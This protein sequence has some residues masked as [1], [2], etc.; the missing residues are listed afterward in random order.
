[1]RL[2]AI[3]IG[4]NSVRCTVV[5]VP[6]GGPRVRLDD[7][8]AY[9]RL[10]RGT[11]V[12]GHLDQAAMDETV[13]A[14]GRMLQ[15]ARGR[16]V[17]HVRAVATA[18]VRNAANGPAFVARIRE[19]LGLDVEVISEEHEGRLA[20]LSAAEAVG[21][22]GRAAVVDIGGA[23]VE[24]VRS[25]GGDITSAVSLP[26]GAVVTTERF[27]SQNRLSG[28]AHKELTR[29]V[30]ALLAEALTDESAA[31]IVVGS[32]GTVVAIAAL[33]SA[34]GAAT[35]SGL[36]GLTVSADDVSR[37]RRM[38]VASSAA[39]RTAMKGMPASR[40]D[41][42]TAGAVVLDEAL[43]ALGAPALTVNARGMRE[44]IIIEA[45]QRERGVE[46]PLDRMGWIR[47]F[48]R[49]CRSDTLHAEQVRRLA[50]ELFDGLAGG[51]GLD[52]ASRPLLEAAALLH[53]VGYCVAYE[54]H[55]KHSHHLISHAELPGF[56]PEE[57]MLIAGIARYHRG[58]LPKMKHPEFGALDA[59]GRGTVERLA[60]LLRVAD[61]LDRS[62]AQRVGRLTVA[63]GPECAEVRITGVPPL[64][65][66]I[67]GAE[68]KADLFE[69]VFDRR[70]VVIAEPPAGT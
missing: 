4:S 63:W 7:E 40:V 33:V 61:G 11:A 57:R 52:P 48:G 69:R 36:H 12:T 20:F 56:G 10:G 5:D 34:E 60:A 55:H 30:R 65:A 15:I 2:A 25:V 35:S 41:I 39:E 17:T 18:A 27:G 45:V 31:E 23:S 21:L 42:I 44:G 58:A 26:L 6:V 51:A 16:E 22:A 43:R 14:L 66:E 8:K 19:E 50:L 53:D 67:H 49:S 59:D 29:H 24:I 68:R 47:G 37:V 3:D 46:P 32:G 54:S 13:E 62:Q 28:P 1:M 38:L 70:V 9:T 64:D